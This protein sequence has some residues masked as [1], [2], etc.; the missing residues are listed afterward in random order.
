[1]GD[2][3][4]IMNTSIAKYESGTG[5]TQTVATTNTGTTGTTGVVNN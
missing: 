5:S 3:T 1:M 4:N 2:F